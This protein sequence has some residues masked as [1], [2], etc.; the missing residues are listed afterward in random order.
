MAYWLDQQGP[1]WVESVSQKV[2]HGFA[3]CVYHMSNTVASRIHWL[4]S[5]PR[6]AK[7]RF[8]HLLTPIR[9]CP[10]TGAD[11]GRAPGLRRLLTELKIGRKTAVARRDLTVAE[12][13]VFG[14]RLRYDCPKRPNLG[15]FPTN[16]PEYTPP[17]PLPL[18]SRSASRTSDRWSIGFDPSRWRASTLAQPRSKR[19]RR[20]M[21]ANMSL[22]IRGPLRSPSTGAKHRDGR[23]WEPT[24]P[25]CA[26][27]GDRAAAILTIAYA[28]S[29]ESRPSP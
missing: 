4:R 15:V 12:Q 18:W 21:A 11:V 1:K 9:Q 29:N 3:T 7:V 17:F 2:W 19:D 13:P 20:G 27:E 10:S 23:W 26:L 8:T 25:D 16:L 28:K 24:C 6:W 22:R 14:S 5:K